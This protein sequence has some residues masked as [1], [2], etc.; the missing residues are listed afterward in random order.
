MLA[1][2]SHCVVV[3]RGNRV[4]SYYSIIGLISVGWNLKI[5]QQALLLRNGVHQLRSR[6]PDVADPVIDW[7]GLMFGRRGK[8]LACEAMFQI[9]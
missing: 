7:P 8:F 4:G 2:P 9:G 3:R 1:P 6:I 5:R